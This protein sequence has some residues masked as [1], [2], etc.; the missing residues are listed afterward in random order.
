[1]ALTE[2]TGSRPLHA[3]AT[4]ALRAWRSE[5]S[6]STR[7][8]RA[9]GIAFMIRVASAA[10]MYISQVLFAR[11]MG[12]FEFGVYVYVWTW[13]LLLGN[14]VD[15]GIATGSQRFI[16][17]YTGRKQLDL[18]TYQ[19]PAG[20]F[21]SAHWFDVH[22][23]GIVAVGFYG[24]GTQLIDVTDATRP[25]S[26]GHAVWGASEVWDAMWVPVYKN[27]RQTKQ[28]TDVVYAID[29]VRGLDVYDVRLP[30]E[31]RTAGSPEGDLS[32]GRVAPM[33]LVGGALAL[34]LLLRRRRRL[35][36]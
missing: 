8:Q 33:G 16:P 23:S 21:C 22:P 1:M 19:V 7:A 15:L 4:D 12:A 36:L 27:G 9:A 13:V 32:L 26:H 11:W 30:G 6:D 2:S 3:R 29:L 24:G 28:R 18:G 10:L 25:V 14:L 35:D 17:E 34:S 5:D 20:A 31:A